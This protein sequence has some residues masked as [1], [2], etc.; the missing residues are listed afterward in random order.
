MMEADQSIIESVKDM[1]LVDVGRNNSQ[2]THIDDTPDIS[3]DS[4][5]KDMEH[6]KEEHISNKDK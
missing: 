2:K 4:Q 3:D 5:E 1:A 6:K